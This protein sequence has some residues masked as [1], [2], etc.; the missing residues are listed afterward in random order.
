MAILKMGGIGTSIVGKIGGQVFQNGTYGTV[1]K[2]NRYKRS[3]QTTVNY[4]QRSRFAYLA[5]VG[6][7]L[8][9]AERAEKTA[10]GL[11]FTRPTKAGPNTTYDWFSL[12][13]AFNGNLQTIGQSIIVGGFLPE[14]PPNI[15]DW[16]VG[17][18]T[19][20]INWEMSG[21]NALDT[22]WY[23][24]VEAS[25]PVDPY[26]AFRG[27]R[28]KIIQ[29]GVGVAGNIVID[30]SNYNLVFGDIKTGQQ[31]WFRITCVLS[32]TGQA[33]TPRITKADAQ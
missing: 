22:P 6:R 32:T 18:E 16:A 10:T 12:H 30:R 4:K 26:A 21:L 27:G 25:G 7:S 33:G 5:A 8:T 24:V 20:T 11:L 15:D 2:N 23:Y 14:T 31:L 13:M 29:T 3:R 9:E 19:G 1:I 17:F 28:M